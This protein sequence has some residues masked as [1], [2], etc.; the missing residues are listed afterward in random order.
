MKSFHFDIKNEVIPHIN[1]A[2]IKYVDVRDRCFFRAFVCGESVIF[3][4]KKIPIFIIKY[5]KK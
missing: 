3:F 4:K 2:S 5:L 1:N